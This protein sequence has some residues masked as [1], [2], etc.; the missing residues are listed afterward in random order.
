MFYRV[1]FHSA[2][3]HIMAAKEVDCADDA[4]ICA[5]AEREAFSSNRTVEV[6]DLA[7]MVTRIEPLTELDGR[8]G[9]VPLA[10]GD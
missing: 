5:I 8:N 2:D 1:F 4:A 9:P 3:N 7:R 6:W 10:I